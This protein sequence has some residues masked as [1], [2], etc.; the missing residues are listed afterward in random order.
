MSIRERT[1][2]ERPGKSKADCRQISRRKILRHSLVSGGMACSG[3]FHFSFKVLADVQKHEE[4][5]GGRQL[6][7]VPFAG[8]GDPPMGEPIGKELDGRLFTDLSRLQPENPVTPTHEFYIRTRASNFLDLSKPWSVQIAG[9][10]GPPITLWA[11]DLEERTRPMGVHLMECAGNS[12]SAHFGML[13][14]ADWEGLPLRD[15]FDTAGMKQPTEAGVLISGFDRYSTESQTSIP[16]ASWIFTMDQLLSSRAFLATKMNGQPLSADHGAPVRLV[17][18]GWY[19]CAC[20]KWVNE[21]A[22]VAEDIAATSQ[23]Q[24]YASRTMQI[25]VPV[26]AR[27][28]HP[29]TIDFAAMPVRIEKWS[30]D[31]QIKYRVVGIRWGGS[32]PVEGLE[33]RFYPEEEFV[34]VENIQPAANESLG[35]WRHLWTPKKAGK[36]VIRLRRRQAASV[37][38]RLDSGYY[39]RSVEITE[40]AQASLSRG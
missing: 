17:V 32:P 20:I 12:R 22:F 4:I 7:V 2:G 33:I 13:G 19:G 38:Q 25:G 18:P 5:A 14:V 11:R 1:E 31:G 27:D 6:G 23:M 34:A 29:A 28:Y 10:R 36:Y 16:G 21:I 15:I 3:L 40:A 9:R 37:S 8:E 24:E 30:V 39:D 35:F 26:F